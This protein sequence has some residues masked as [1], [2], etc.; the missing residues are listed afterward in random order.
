MKMKITMRTLSAGPQGVLD[1]GKTYNVDDKFARDLIT[2]GYA[3]PVKRHDPI[4]VQNISIETATADPA[5]ETALSPRARRT[6]PH[7]KK[8]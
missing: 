8:G 2:G 6:A 4:V 3:V 1:A 7:S 5:P